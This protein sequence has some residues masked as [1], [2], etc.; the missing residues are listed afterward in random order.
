M[1]LG[2][3]H[4]ASA[5]ARYVRMNPDTTGCCSHQAHAHRHD[6]SRYGNV[7]RKFVR[8]FIEFSTGC[9]RMKLGNSRRD[10]SR[11][12]ERVG[13]PASVPLVEN[14]GGR[15]TVT[16]ECQ[17][18]LRHRERHANLRFT[19]ILPPSLEAERNSALMSC[20]CWSRCSSFR[21]SL[22]APTFLRNASGRRFD[23]LDDL[24][25][26]RVAFDVSCWQL[27]EDR[28]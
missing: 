28:V 19:Q 7:S 16:L 18:R 27:F 2:P 25:R 8:R 20:S 13:T 14:S 26:L 6:K 4:A 22:S 21:R 12:I 3:V 10:L 1:T 24:I 9:V 11:R 15:S 17:P 5:S 23:V